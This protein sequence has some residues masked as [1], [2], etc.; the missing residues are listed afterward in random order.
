ALDGADLATVRRGRLG[1]QDGLHGRHGVVSDDLPAH[2]ELDSPAQLER[3]HA[4]AL[5]GRPRLGEVGH[6]LALD[7]E[8]R[9]VVVEP[10]RGH[11][12]RP[13]DVGQRVDGAEPE[14]GADAQGAPVL[15]T[16]G[17]RHG[18]T[19]QRLREG[20]REAGADGG[21]AK[22]VPPR[23]GH[24]RSSRSRPHAHVST[25]TRAYT[26]AA[27]K[28]SR[29]STRSSGIVLYL[30]PGPYTSPIIPARDRCAASVP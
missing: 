7:V 1:V 26:R 22:E 18:G 14:G 28:R 15:V 3:P 20:A 27:L 4:P 12:L 24:D 29:S 11:P 23:I 10:A 8:P 5:G 25:I 21:A 17:P 2:V 30:P 9:E 16:L 6:H 19:G 13:A